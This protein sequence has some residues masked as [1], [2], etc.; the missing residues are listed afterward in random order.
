MK[1]L[2]PFILS[3]LIVSSGN[4]LFAHFVSR[5]TNSASSHYVILDTKLSH[6]ELAAKLQQIGLP[7]ASV[8]TITTRPARLLTLIYHF[9]F[10]ALFL[11][12]FV[13]LV[14]LFQRAFKSDVPDHDHAV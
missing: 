8:Q 9:T 12:A 13:G 14:Y 10:E 1:K 3:F 7:E 11:S 2:I 6:D 4:Y 5:H